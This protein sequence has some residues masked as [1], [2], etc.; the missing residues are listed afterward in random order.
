MGSF[1]AQAR[2]HAHAIRSLVF[3]SVGL[4]ALVDVPLPKNFIDENSMMGKAVNR[5]KP[6]SPQARC[7][8]PLEKVGWD[9]FG[10]CKSA[11]F[12]G[13]Q[14]YAVFVDHCFRYCWVYMLKDKSEM[15]EIVEQFVAGTALIRQLLFA[16]TI[17]CAACVVIML[18]KMFHRYSKLG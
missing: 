12:G 18:V 2:L 3:R 7:L 10:P 6:D 1:A 11:S 16:K 17:L 5:D 8:A 14:Y 13:H 15:P 9:I 4:E